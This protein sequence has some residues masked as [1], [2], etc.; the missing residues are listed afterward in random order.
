MEIIIKLYSV[1]VRQ[2]VTN[3]E[4]FIFIYPTPCRVM[5]DDNH[6]TIGKIRIVA[7]AFIMVEG[8]K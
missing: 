6:R 4:E 8:N 5:W 3:E 1:P 2:G 7:K